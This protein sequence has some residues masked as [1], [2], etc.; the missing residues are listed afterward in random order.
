MSRGRHAQPP[1]RLT[2]RGRI[3]RDMVAGAGLLGVVVL[4]Q[5]IS[6]GYFTMVAWVG[7]V[8]GTTA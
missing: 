7:Q 2:H 6:V 4:A 5:P 1:V 8:T 3:V